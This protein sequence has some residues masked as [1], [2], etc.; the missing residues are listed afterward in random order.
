VIATTLTVIAVFGPVGFLKGMVGQFFKQFGITVCFAMMI[1]LFDALT[2][3]PMLSTYFAGS[4]HKKKKS[5]IYRYTLG[6]VLGAF[7][8]FQDALEDF[9]EG[10]LRRTVNHPLISLLVSFIIAAACFATVAKVPKTFLPPQ[11]NGE[12][13]VALD[14]PPGTSLAAMD[15][16]TKK[17]DGVIRGNREVEL[18]S[19]SVGNQYG[20]ANTADMYVHLIPA[21]ARTL[22]TSQVKEKIREQLKEYAEANPKV[23][24]FDAVGGGMRPFNLNIIG[25]DQD[26]LE[27]HAR[28]VFEE[29]RRHPGLKDVDINSKPG[30]P[31][32]QVI[33]DQKKGEALGVSNASMG[34]ELRTLIEG[35]TPAKF[36]IGGDEYDIRVRLQEDQRNLRERFA[37][38]YVP[39]INFNLI[40]LPDVAKPTDTVGPAKITR[41]D[42]GRYIQIS[43]DITPGAGLGNIMQDIV[44][45][46]ETTQKLPT[47]LSYGFL[48][49]AEDF[50]ELME[51]MLVA[52]GFGIL[53][54]YLVLSSLYESFITP[55]T[56]MLALPLA[57]CGSMLALFLAHQ[58][59]N[60]FSII[61]L[62]LLLGVATKNSIL[63]VDYTNQLIQQGLDR[64][65]AII[66]AGRTRLRPILMTTMALIAGTVPVAL[67]L[68]EASRQR[69][70]MGVAIIGGLVSSTFLTLIV[71]PAAFC[72]VDDFRQWVNKI[73]ARVRGES[74]TLDVAENLKG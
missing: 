1:S 9:Y 52:L 31:E 47:G 73:F 33:M 24:D 27:K 10:L 36:R 67:G 32:L 49:Q 5:A 13:T 46:F 68:N 2:I 74:V 61:G 50:K 44:K 54:I 14:L 63:L 38:T 40:R 18:T 35:S 34:A 71:I 23:K 48:G 16:M 58:S 62:I 42:R 21:K 60:I 70:S 28:G 15:A 20:E 39:N 45:M 3:A 17:I 7:N 8:R 69:T 41:Q 29:L 72:F 12:F 51:N 59:V 66:K 64:P 43:A 53:F 37:T 26:L 30:K 22:N 65:S 25:T 19:Y 4:S 57:I 56:I 11:D 55:F 6:V